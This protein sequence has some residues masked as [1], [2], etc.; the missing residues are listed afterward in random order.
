MNYE[1][2]DSGEGRRLEKWG[3]YTLDRPDPETLW[4]KA[5]PESDWQK[6]DAVFKGNWINKNHVP[7]RW[8]L[9]H[10]GIKFWAKLA[11][12]KHTGVFP[13]QSGQWEWINEKITQ[14][15]NKPIYQ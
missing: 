10:E 5:L 14:S 6:A 8:Q 15:T 3:P 7:E 9:E 11:P 4:K 12:F 2:I 13:E 1:L